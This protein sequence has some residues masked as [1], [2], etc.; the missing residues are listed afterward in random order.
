MYEGVEGWKETHTEEQ[1][2]VSHRPDVHVVGLRLEGNPWGEHV[3]T[4]VRVK[5]TTFWL[6]GEPLNHPT[7]AHPQHSSTAYFSLFI[8]L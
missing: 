6:W 3:N 1:S 7:P 2:H 4:R 5:L 8:S